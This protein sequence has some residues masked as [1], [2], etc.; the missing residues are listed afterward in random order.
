MIRQIISLPILDREGY[1]V[2]IKYCTLHLYNKDS[3]LICKY[4][5]FNGHYVL[6]TNRDVFN[7]KENKRI[8]SDINNMNYGI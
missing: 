4:S 7:I 3:L 1:N 8:R 5:L 2:N 6:E